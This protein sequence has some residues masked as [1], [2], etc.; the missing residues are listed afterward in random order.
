MTNDQG[1]VSQVMRCGPE[2]TAAVFPE[3]A[4]SFEEITM[5]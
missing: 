2:S 5:R 1:E 4:G 3:Q